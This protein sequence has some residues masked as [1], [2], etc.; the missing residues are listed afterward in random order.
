MSRHSLRLPAVVAKTG[1]KKTQ[2]LEAVD[3][4]IFPKPFRLIPG[5]RAMAWD[6][7]EIDEHLAQQMAHH[8]VHTKEV[9][10]VPGPNGHGTVCLGF[11][12]PR[13]KM[14]FEAFDADTA[15]LGLF[16]T[17]KAAADA[18]TRAAGDGS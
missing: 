16:E 11:V 1:L 18:V 7:D 15:S 13:G 4:G 6:E 10:Y 2:I 3:K 17:A 9:V 12:F 5:G 14:G 8:R